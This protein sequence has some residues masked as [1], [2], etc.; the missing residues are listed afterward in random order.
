MSSPCSAQI[1]G[2]RRSAVFR[3]KPGITIA[4]YSYSA[5]RQRRMSGVVPS[6]VLAYRSRLDSDYCSCPLELDGYPYDLMMAFVGG[7]YLALTLHAGG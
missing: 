7:W 6:P 4:A 2:V 3:W 1:L 5:L